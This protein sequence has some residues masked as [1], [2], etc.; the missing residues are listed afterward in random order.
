MTGR[1]NDDGEGVGDA[2]GQPQQHPQ[3]DQIP[4]EILARL[5]VT[6][7]EG[8]TTLPPSA[9]PGEQR[10]SDVERNRQHGQT[11]GQLEPH[12]EVHY[13]HGGCLAG[14]GDP[15]HRRDNA[16]GHQPAGCLELVR[17]AKDGVRYGHA[18]KLSIL[19]EKERGPS[20]QAER[21][22]FTRR[23][24]TTALPQCRLSL[25]PASSKVA[26]PACSAQ[27]DRT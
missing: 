22:T 14:D 15:A 19:A 16:E 2:A 8:V 1:E 6:Q 13:E 27:A 11:D 4:G 12:G 9:L 21:A 7:P 5:A 24:Q 23:C 10:D 3:L 20:G 25:T 17:G 18:P 26:I